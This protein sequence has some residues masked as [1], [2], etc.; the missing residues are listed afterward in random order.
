MG[1]G[2]LLIV[3]GLFVIFGVIQL[4]VN[5][6][7][8]QINNINISHWNKAQARNIAHAGM[9]SAFNRIAS[10]VSW[11][12]GTNTPFTFAF[13]ADTAF[14]H[15][16]DN[17]MAGVTLAN[18]IVEIRSTGRVN[19]VSHQARAQ[20]FVTGGLPPVDA[21][22]GI[23]TENL[24]FNVA[25]A[26]FLINGV[27]TNPDGTAGP[28]G[29]LPGISVN[30][31]AAYHEVM[32]GL[33][34]TQQRNRVQGMETDPNTLSI[35][36]ETVEENQPSL[37]YNPAMDPS[38]LEEFVAKAKLNADATYT[39]FT[40]SGT[41]SLG[42]PSNPKIIVVNG[43]LDV[44]NATGAGIIII[45][46]TGRLDAR[47]NLDNYQGLIIVQG[48]ADMT[49]GNIN[50]FGAMLFGGDSPHIEID[51]DFRGNVAVQYSSQVINNLNSQLYSS[52]EKRHQILT[53]LD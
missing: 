40:A 52:T 36:N 9:E 12:T 7:H 30:N 23:F 41:G 8:I 29:A 37:N 16:L 26:A 39:N 15:V 32:N 48:S 17:T 28:V 4:S 25:G 3:T 6:R 44:S 2:M 20:L 33:A 53:Y 34:T 47:G 14:V 49:R 27:D 45:T 5:S 42:T 19:G 35:I 1:R 10:Q 43:V 24:D 18:G 46:E 22:M 11:R 31:E 50:I 38:L 13:G 21:A 51:I